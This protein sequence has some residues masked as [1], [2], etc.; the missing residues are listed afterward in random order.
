MQDTPTVPPAQDPQLTVFYDG[1]CPLCRS[2]IGHYQACQGADQIAFVNVA[3]ADAGVVSPGLDR[4]TAI[5]RFHV[6]DQTG[7]LKS[8]AEGFAQLWLLL[9]RWRWLGR[10]VLRPFVLPLAE[11]SY[12]SF[13]FLRPAIQ[14]LWRWRSGTTT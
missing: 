6:L 8:G 1:D 10:F 4:A 11:R 9:P 14:R 13:L 5:A 3:T 2:E 7:R 12:T